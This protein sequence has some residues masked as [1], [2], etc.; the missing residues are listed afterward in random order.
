MPALMDYDMGG[1]V[2]IA[3]VTVALE[4]FRHMHTGKHLDMWAAFPT[5]KNREM[6]SVPSSCNLP[7]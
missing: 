6:S 3:D 5:D 2:L 1:H 4:D 7:P